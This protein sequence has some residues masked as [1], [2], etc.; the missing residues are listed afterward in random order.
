MKGCINFMEPR[1]TLE[2]A[3][4]TFNRRRMLRA[5]GLLSV[6]VHDVWLDTLRAESAAPKISKP[7][8]SCVF[9]FLFGG[10]SQVDWWDLKPDAPAEIR[11]TFA[12]IATN[13]AGIQ[14]GEHL[15]LLARQ[16]DKLCLV[17]SMTHR[18]PVHG[19]AC[20]E[21][22][23]GRPYFGAPTT[24]Q[25]RPEDWPSIAAM[26][27]RFGRPGGSLPHSIVLPWHTQFVG[28]DKRIAG[29]TG[30]RMGEEFNPFLIAG[31]LNDPK[32][33]VQGLRLP[34]DMSSV[35]FSRRRELRNRIDS[36]GFA[37]SRRTFQTQVAES[38]F[39][40]AVALV[41]RT[42]A[43]GV[44]DLNRETPEV[45]DRYGRTRFGQSLLMARRLV[46]AGTSLIT[47]NWDDDHKDDKVSPHWDTHV[48]NF[49]KLKDRL[50]PPF[51][52]AVAAF[53]EDLSRRGLL[54]STLVVALGEF[55]RTPRI[56]LVT[57]NGGTK[58]TGRDHWPHAYTAL[59]AGGGI[60][61]GQVHGATD[62]T[63]GHVADNPVSPADLAA[64]IF[65]HLG[66][67]DR[68]EYDDQFLQIRQR[69]SNGRPIA[70]S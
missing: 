16:M 63:G 23:S 17:R 59:V 52:R 43:A 69:L 66:I 61:G 50:C 33:R 19:P 32:F 40:A 53:V 31:N 15:P 14:I 35:R 1:Q 37:E 27:H 55:G 2:T 42:E 49:P 8:R 41:E 28:Q 68:L 60:R 44:L 6:G 38:N 30:G 25:A 70:W 9:I 34:V 39:Q 22:Y 24:D 10:Q 3:D 4:G 26:V 13:V 48:D 54:E 21:V 51:D 18:M 47:V 64:T 12:P 57:Q 11:G 65:H 45:R 56:G 67:D 20:S 36:L 46:E 29:Q 58:K 7:T 62:A 5:A